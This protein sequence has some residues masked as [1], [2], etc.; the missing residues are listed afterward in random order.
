MKI[1]AG[2]RPFDVSCDRFDF[3][4]NYVG[5]TSVG[6]LEFWQLRW[7]QYRLR[8]TNRLFPLLGGMYVFVGGTPGSFDGGKYSPCGLGLL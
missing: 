4:I 1:I 5:M 6:A 8:A 7:S 2:D 3:L